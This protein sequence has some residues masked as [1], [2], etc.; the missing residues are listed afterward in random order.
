MTTS[1]VERASYLKNGGQQDKRPRHVCAAK[2]LS[3]HQFLRHAYSPPACGCAA[4][5]A[6]GLIFLRAY[7]A[8]VRSIEM[9]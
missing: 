3:A 4:N 6:L 5:P 2:T 1:T 8:G 9:D 7:C